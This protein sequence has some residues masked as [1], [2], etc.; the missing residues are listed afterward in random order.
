MNYLPTTHR[1]R[2]LRS[3]VLGRAVCARPPAPAPAAAMAAWDPGR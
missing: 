2:P 3:A 1:A